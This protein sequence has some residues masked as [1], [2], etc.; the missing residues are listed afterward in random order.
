MFA[1][2]VAGESGCPTLHEVE[3]NFDSDPDMNRFPALGARLK[4]PLLDSLNGGAVFLGVQ[5]L[6]HFYIAGQAVGRYGG[7]Q[8]DD[9][10][11]KGF[12]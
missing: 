11:D 8:P 10:F 4:A 1:P 6:S 2:Q 3:G 12:F 9:A 5:A 7:F